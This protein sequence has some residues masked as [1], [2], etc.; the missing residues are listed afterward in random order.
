[1]TTSRRYLEVHTRTVSSTVFESQPGRNV[2]REKVTMQRVKQIAKAANSGLIWKSILATTVS[3]AV[4]GC[5]GGLSPASYN[6][7]VV[8]SHNKITGSV[9][10]GQQ[11][12]QGAAIQ[13]YAVGTSGLKSAATPLITPGLVTSDINGDFS[14][15]GDYSCSGATQV[16]LTATG[17]DAGAGSNSAINLMAPVGLCST[18]IA[19]PST[20]VQINEVTT[21]AS[22]YALAPFMSDY[23]H[24]G[25]SGSNP[26]GLVNAVANFSNLA[27]ITTGLAGGGNLPVG[28]TVPVSEINTLADIIAS[29]INSTGSTSSPCTTLLGATG[30]TD[31]IGATLAIAQNPGSSAYTAL[32][33]LSTSTPPFAPTLAAKP[34]DW[35]IAMTYTA[36]GAISAPSGVAIDAAGNA[37]ITSGSGTSTTNGLVKLSSNGNLLGNYTGGGLL[38]AKALAIDRSGNVWVANPATSSIIEFSSTG[39]VLSGSNG[40]TGGGINGPNALAIDSG[41]NV[42]IANLNGTTVTKL[43]STGS[44]ATGNGS[45][46]FSGSGSIS[47]PSGIAIDSTGNAWIANYGNSNVVK[48]TNAGA[49]SSGSPFSDLALQG[50]SSIAL[51]SA[52]NAWVPGATT[53]TVLAGAVS[54]FSNSGVAS[55]SSP[56]IGGGLLYSTAVATSGTTAWVTNKKPGSGL[57]EIVLGQNAPSSP[58]AGFGSLNSPSALAVDPSG[59]I[60]TANSGDNTVSQFIGLTAPV[61]API[62]ANVGP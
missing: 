4:S 25:A 22:V 29:C 34:N 14:I 48:L 31:T 2:G 45:S 3:M 27:N 56:F 23:K 42:W 33:T 47:L 24:I 16:Y 50:P 54:E 61:V 17:G 11:P 26:T 38:G 62:A 5:S 6:S 1:M 51:D 46:G 53:G 13:L 59:D 39:S 60:W 18:L 8:N 15:T 35:T 12:V 32:Y 40:F 9:F 58:A 43:N 7:I 37:W 28:A 55:T 41:G 20:F 36:G 10:G 57:T 30:A 44:P 52:G 21:V 19:N 49:V